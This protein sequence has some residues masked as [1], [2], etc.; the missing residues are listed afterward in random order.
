MKRVYQIYIFRQNAWLRLLHDPSSLFQAAFD[1]PRRIKLPFCH[2]PL[3]NGILM[4]IEGGKLV[5]FTFVVESDRGPASYGEV[6][7]AQVKQ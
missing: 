1:V 2:E 6:P 5:T 4:V 3:P 7:P